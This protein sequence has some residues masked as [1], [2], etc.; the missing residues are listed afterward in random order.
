MYESYLVLTSK[1]IEV[2]RELENGKG[3]IHVCRPLTQIVKITAK[4]R[5]RDL[6]TFKYGVPDGENLIITGRH[7]RIFCTNIKKLNFF[8]RYG[9]IFNPQQ[10][11][12]HQ[13]HFQV[14]S[15]AALSFRSVLFYYKIFSLFFVEFVLN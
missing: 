3:K 5:H 7:L 2:I 8:C 1:R 9:Q 12:G 4:K 6:I 14:H 13:N 11:R 10:S 15:A